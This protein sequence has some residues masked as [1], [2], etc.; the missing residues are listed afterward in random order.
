MQRDA[1]LA[2]DVTY[3]QWW[4]ETVL[5]RG[6]VIH[7][8]RC[9][10]ELSSLLAPL[11]HTASIPT[12]LLIPK[13]LVACIRRPPIVQLVSLAEGP[14]RAGGKSKMEGEDGEEEEKEKLEEQAA[15]LKYVL[16]DLA[17]E[18]YIE[19]LEGFHK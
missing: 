12:Y 9:L 2:D 8:A 14:E 15:T 13:Y 6:Y 11:V 19:L 17:S 5:E 3:V 4:E 1:N 18:L 10:S 7:R 16:H